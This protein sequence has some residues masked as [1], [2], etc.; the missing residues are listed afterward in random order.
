[1]E[2]PPGFFQGSELPRLLILAIV[3]VV[4]WALVWHF[5]RRLPQPPSPISWRP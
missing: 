5:A 2:R 4:G 3:M 1:M